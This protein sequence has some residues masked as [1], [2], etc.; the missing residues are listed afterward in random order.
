MDERTKRIARLWARMT[1]LYGSR[2]EIEYGPAHR[3]DGTMAIIAGHWADALDGLASDRIA[4]GLRACVDRENL[5]PPSMPEFLRLCGY[6]PKT[7]HP[8]YRAETQAAPAL[9]APSGYADSPR[10]R[11][12]RL[13]LELQSAAE[14]EFGPTIA[15]YP[16]D[17]RRKTVARYWLTG[18]AAIPGLGHV[19]S[20]SLAKANPEAA[21]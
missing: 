21:A 17:A 15:H 14:S 2:W 19:V 5:N 8:A 10:A 9:P 16:H 1:A 11:C 12:E 7:H 18:I 13:A 6:R 4:A 20:K 3:A